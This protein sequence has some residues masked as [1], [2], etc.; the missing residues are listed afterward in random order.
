MVAD[1]LNRLELTGEPDDP[2]LHLAQSI[3]LQRRP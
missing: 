1:F 2:M 3:A